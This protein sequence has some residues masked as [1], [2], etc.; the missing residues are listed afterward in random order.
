[1]KQFR[2]ILVPVDFSESSQKALELAVSFDAEVDALH[3]WEPPSVVALDVQV[4][5]PG[6][7]QTLVEHAR[8]TAEERMQELLAAVGRPVGSAVLVG[9]PADTIVE[10]AE[11]GG[12]DLVVM[13]THGRRGVARA[14]IG[15]VAEQVVRRAPCPVLTVR[16]KGAE[17]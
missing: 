5:N 1:M 6:Q 14:V 17:R 3:V 7:T 16:E 4:F 11:E 15:S 2:K 12:Y 9:S 8:R 13:G 10:R